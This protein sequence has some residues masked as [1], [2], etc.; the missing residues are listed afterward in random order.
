M[1]QRIKAKDKT[2]GQNR[3]LG[4][5]ANLSLQYRTSARKLR[6]KARVDYDI[7]MELPEAQR[8]W[9]TYQRAYPGV[10]AYWEKQI[11]L[12]KALGYVETFGG[13]RVRVE[14]DWNGKYGWGMGSTAI[15]TRI[16][17]TGADQK[18]LAIANIIPYLRQ[19]G[20]RFLFDLHDG[21]YL[22]IPSKISV[23]ACRQIKYLLDNLPYK[24]AWGFQPPIPMPWDCKIGKA[25]GRMKELEF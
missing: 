15:N 4:K 21:V 13:N 17:G 18:H 16:Q 14:G 23:D 11:A 1:L 22:A 6:V 19:I 2:A 7:P 12:V 3:Y 25:W 9:S 24:K 20:G 5:F 8:I 10:P